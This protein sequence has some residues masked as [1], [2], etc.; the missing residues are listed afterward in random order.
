MVALFPACPR[1]LVPS[2]PSHQAPLWLESAHRDLKPSPLSRQSR[3]HSTGHVPEPHTSALVLGPVDAWG[4]CQPSLGLGVPVRVLG[5]CPDDFGGLA[6]LGPQH[7]LWPLWLCHR[8]E[9][10]A[11][12]LAVPAACP[13]RPS[14]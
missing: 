13:S 10:P 12:P 4:S 7:T 5:A 9:T 8:Q 1:P 14:R 3:K 11:G 2:W 6:A